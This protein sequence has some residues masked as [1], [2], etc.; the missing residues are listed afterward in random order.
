MPAQPTHP[1]ITLTAEVENYSTAVTI[2]WISAF[3]DG[4][5]A[6]RTMAYRFEQRGSLTHRKLA[7][8]FAEVLR[9]VGPSY[10]T[11]ERSAAETI[12]ALAAAKDAAG[13][14]VA[15]HMGNELAFCAA[16]LAAETTAG[17]AA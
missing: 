17:G 8:A 2:V 12:L 11:G 15:V 10:A 13:D 9:G 16:L 5:P 4:R 3:V 7:S 6:D 14:A 1:R